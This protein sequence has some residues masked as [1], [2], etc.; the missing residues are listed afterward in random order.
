MLGG[1]ADGPTEQAADEPTDPM[2][3]LPATSVDPL[4]ADLQTLREQE[5]FA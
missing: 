3:E 1:G 2:S 4:R 5:L